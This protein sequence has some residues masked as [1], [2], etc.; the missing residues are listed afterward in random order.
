MNVFM[1]GSFWAWRCRI[2]TRQ[3]DKMASILNHSWWDTVALWGDN[4]TKPYFQTVIVQQTFYSRGWQEKMITLKTS[5][6][7]LQQTYCFT[8]VDERQTSLSNTTTVTWR[9]TFVNFANNFVLS[10][11]LYANTSTLSRQNWKS[12]NF[13]SQGNQSSGA[14][15][16]EK[17]LQ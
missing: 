13:P 9:T 2:M 17:L 12:A 4:L 1:G 3:N 14:D 8:H 10:L 7:T 5:S 6:E 16:A 15:R 11:Y